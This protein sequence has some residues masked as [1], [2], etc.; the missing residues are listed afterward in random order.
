MPTYLSMHLN[1]SNSVY[2]IYSVPV[3]KAG[4][5]I[6]DSSKCEIEQLDDL[7]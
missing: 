1:I 6:N 5:G 2:I 7:L 3:S 4:C